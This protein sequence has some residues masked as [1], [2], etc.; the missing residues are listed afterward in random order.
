MDNGEHPHGQGRVYTL[1]HTDPRK[2]WVLLMPL[3]VCLDMA[4]GNCPPVHPSSPTYIGLSSLDDTLLPQLTNPTPM[5]AAR[6]ICGLGTVE[7]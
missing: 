1:A 7:E 4:G 6:G 5:L 2:D 3:P